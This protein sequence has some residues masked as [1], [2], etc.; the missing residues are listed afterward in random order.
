MAPGEELFFDYG[1][2]YWDCVDIKK[3]SVPRK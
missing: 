3:G 2:S 1:E